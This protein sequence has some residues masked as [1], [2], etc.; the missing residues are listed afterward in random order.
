[1][2]GEWLW[3]TMVCYD[4]FLDWL[5]SVRLCWSILWYVRIRPCK[6]MTLYFGF[7]LA[8]AA[9]DRTVVWVSFGPVQV[10]NTQEREVKRMCQPVVSR[11]AMEAAL[12]QRNLVI[13]TGMCTK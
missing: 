10:E 8:D 9:V 1:M 2:S 7:V 5:N 6:Y 3:Y 11:A 4:I 13:A 12:T